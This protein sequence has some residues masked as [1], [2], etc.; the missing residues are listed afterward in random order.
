MDEEISTLKNDFV[1]HS[2]ELMAHVK[3]LL[4][5]HNAF[6]A[7]GVIFVILVYF[8]IYKL[9][10]KGIR[11]VNVQKL[12]DER[13]SILIRVAR[14]CFYFAVVVYVLGLFGIKLSA[15]WGAAGIA[16]VAIGFAA[17][18]SVSN[19]I[20][21]LFIVSEKSLKIG[22]AIIVNGV[23]GVVDAISLLSVRVHTYDNQMVRIPNSSIINSTLTNNSYN[24]YRRMLISVSIAYES[25]LAFALETLKKAPE[26]CP[27]ARTAPAPS[28]WIDGFGSSGITLTLAIWFN[29]SDFVAVKNETYIAIKKV[30]D[31][32]KISIP[33]NQ[34]VV[35]N[36]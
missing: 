36:V 1:S 31:E 15:I 8:V 19:L 34:I 24:S 6:F 30:F 29:N 10:C 23:T 21:G 33:F 16:G 17:Q 22:D 2:Q 28:A 4:T 32:A 26:Y 12:S 14:Y 11:K 5:I 27:T 7:A 18:T 35:R 25:D 9:V 3:G 20:S 13:K